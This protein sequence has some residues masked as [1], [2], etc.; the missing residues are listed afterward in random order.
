MG[1]AARREETANYALEVSLSGGYGSV[2]EA[3]EPLPASGLRFDQTLELVG[4]RFQ[5]ASAIDGSL[6]TL[7]IVPSGL[8]IDNSPI[9][10]FIDGTVTG[11]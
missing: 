7:S 4:I 9:V 6:N 10:R 3:S 1:D 2:A 8:E 5:V 11:S